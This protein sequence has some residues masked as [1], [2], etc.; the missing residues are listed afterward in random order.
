M[1]C[2]HVT[3]S[4]AMGVLAVLAVLACAAPAVCG[5]NP[6]EAIAIRLSDKSLLTFGARNLTG[7]N[8]FWDST[9]P[10]SNESWTQYA[11]ASTNAIF[12][13][14]YQPMFSIRRNDGIQ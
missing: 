11:L 10:F 2:T 5:S 6:C 14:I 13:S 9:I 4:I 8:I 1:K 3:G 12:P 7:Q